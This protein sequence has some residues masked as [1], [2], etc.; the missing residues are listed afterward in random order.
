M[1]KI[2]LKSGDIVQVIAGDD[3]GKTGKIMSVDRKKGLLYV[4]GVNMHKKH[5]RA[6]PQ[7]NQP[8]GIIESEGPIQPSNVKLVN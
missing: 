8:G 2:R 3:M 7:N 1:H 5:R 6:N 4:E